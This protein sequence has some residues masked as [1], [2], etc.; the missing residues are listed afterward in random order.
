MTGEGLY[1]QKKIIKMVMTWGWF[2]GLLLVY[3]THGDLVMTWG[4]FSGDVVMLSWGDVV[5]V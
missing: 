2:S 1:S 3:H 4:W 5:M